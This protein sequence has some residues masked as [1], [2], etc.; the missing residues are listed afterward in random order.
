MKCPVL[1]LE[2]VEAMSPKMDTHCFVHCQWGRM[3]APANFCY[4][5]ADINCSRLIIVTAFLTTYRLGSLAICGSQLSTASSF[6]T[7]EGKRLRTVTM[8]EILKAAETSIA[9]KR[10]D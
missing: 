6:H 4:L 7:K 8:P 10:L 2:G 1:A 9:S 5:E 3:A